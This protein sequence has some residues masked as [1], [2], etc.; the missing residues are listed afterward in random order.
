MHS[1]A[2]AEALIHAFEEGWAECENA[3]NK[4]RRVGDA[5]IEPSPQNNVHVVVANY[6][7]TDGARFRMRFTHDRNDNARIVL[8]EDDV[9]L[10]RGFLDDINVYLLDAVANAE[11]SSHEKL[12][13]LALRKALDLHAKAFR[14]CTKTSNKANGTAAAAVAPACLSVTTDNN[15]GKKQADEHDVEG[16]ART[17]TS[18]PSEQQSPA[19][20]RRKTSLSVAADEN[21]KVSAERGVSASTPAKRRKEAIFERFGSTPLAST[22]LMKQLQLLEKQ[23]TRADGFEAAPKGDDL[24]TW[25]VKLYF[26]DPNTSLSRDLAKLDY[27]DFVELE[28]KFP[29]LYP[30]E[31]PVVRFVAP[32]MKRGGHVTTHGAICMEL[33]TGSGWSPV[34]SIDLVCIQIRAML[35]A[36]H[37]RVEVA[38]PRNVSRYSLGGALADLHSIVTAHRWTVENARTVKRPRTE[39]EF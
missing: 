28:F 19:S 20:P 13:G 26:D 38:C 14:I 15:K 10:P 35:L 11:K 6:E 29:S 17:G 33:L 1:N 36:G 9:G 12:V 30:S 3:C 25:Q 22:T 4:L 7:F 27:I 39:P 8:I 2:A 24:Y 32:S 23:D 21:G 34:N 16:G 31:P 37:A 18:P 5:R